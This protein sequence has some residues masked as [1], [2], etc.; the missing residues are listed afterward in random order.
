MLS[1]DE[2]A[3]WL[4]LGTTP[5][6]GRGV[7]RKLLA[8][9][10]SA[11]RVLAADEP[12]LLSLTGRDVVR[13]LKRRGAPDD[14]QLAATRRW[15]DASP[16]NAPRDIV[17]LEDPRYPALLLET[18][19]PPLLLFTLGRVALLSAPSVAIVGSRQATLQGMDNARGFARFLSD[20]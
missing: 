6:V 10:G 3:A 14:A 20:A 19:D 16:A 18:A 1:R 7:A 2:L 15:L 17:T 8:A 5:G 9:L 12:T 13:L 4:R 11:E